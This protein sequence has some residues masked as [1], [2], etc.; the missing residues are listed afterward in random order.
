MTASPEHGPMVQ[1][2]LLEL[3]VPLAARAQEHFQELLREFTLIAT[4]TAS[5]G[6][7]APARLLQLVDVI[8]RQF[9]GMNTAAEDRLEDAISSG[10]PVIDD[11]VLEVPPEAGPAAQALGAMIDEAEEY[12]RQG[13]HLLTLAAPPELVAYRHWYLQQ[14][15]DQLAGKPPVPWP[16]YA[17]TT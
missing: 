11:H 4:D 10:R 7:H 8:T 15:I 12:C 3:P 5:D 13:Q 1:A 9:G 17:A 6:E 14:V 16:Q 2:H